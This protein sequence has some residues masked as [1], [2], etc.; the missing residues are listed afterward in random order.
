MRQADNTV[1]AQTG[2]EEKAAF[3]LQYVEARHAI[4]KA[5]VKV[6]QRSEGRVLVE[7]FPVRMGGANGKVRVLRA[8]YRESSASPANAVLEIA[9]YLD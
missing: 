9:A 8:A 1:M 2:F 7:A 6:V 5:A 4:R 3:T